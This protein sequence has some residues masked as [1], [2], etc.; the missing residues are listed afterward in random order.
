MSP[1]L[2]PVFQYITV[3][4]NL[5]LKS[6]EFYMLHKRKCEII[7]QCLVELNVSG[8]IICIIVEFIGICELENICVMIQSDDEIETYNCSKMHDNVNKS[9]KK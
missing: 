5:F 8:D 2:Q 1:Y 3:I 9:K 6:F 4:Q 7:G